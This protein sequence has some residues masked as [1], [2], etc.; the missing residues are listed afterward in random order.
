[1]T[2]ILRNSKLSCEKAWTQKYGFVVINLWENAYCA[3]YLA[4]YAEIYTPSNT[5]NEYIKIHKNT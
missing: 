5:P 1:M 4:N 2:W 3:R